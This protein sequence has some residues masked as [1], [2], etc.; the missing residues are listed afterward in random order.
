MGGCCQ[1]CGYNK[2][3]EALEFHHIDPNEKDFTFGKVT[4]NPKNKLSIV[5]ELKKC[6]LVCANCHREIH[7]DR[8]VIPESFCKVDASVI[9]EEKTDTRIPCVVC[10]NLH[11]ARNKTCSN[12]CAGKLRGKIDWDNV[13][14]ESKLKS[15]MNYTSIGDELGCSG[16]AVS[17]RAY[18]L[19]IQHLKY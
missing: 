10:G 3:N 8:R 2:C 9:L 14:L 15:G 18:K 4:A 12:S 16:A 5:E 1:C 7:N 17:K 11:N 19:N 6:I 13:D